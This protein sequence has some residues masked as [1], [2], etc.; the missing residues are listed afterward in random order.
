MKD[1]IAQDNENAFAC[2]ALR[3]ASGPF[4]KRKDAVT[5]WEATFGPNARHGLKTGRSGYN[6]K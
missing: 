2:Y 5:F 4:N 1:M 6:R 3:L